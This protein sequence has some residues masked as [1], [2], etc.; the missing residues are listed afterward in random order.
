MLHCNNFQGYDLMS[1]SKL[2]QDATPLTP[3]GFWQENIA[4]WQ[5]FNQR[6]GQLWI[7]QVQRVAT[8]PDP[9]AEL[10]ETMTADLLRTVSD[11]NLRHWQNLASLLDSLPDWMTAPTLV[12]AAS[13]TDWFDRRRRAFQSGFD[14]TPK[15]TASKA[16]IVPAANPDDLTRIKG[17]GPKL[18]E[19]LNTLGVFRF[20]QIADWSA[21]DIDWIDTQV[22]GKGRIT[23]EDWVSQARLLTANG[24]ATVH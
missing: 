6:T 24:E 14:L 10:A 19:K 13:L 4:T 22:A 20:A 11:L 5:E 12:N 8:R 23:R 3:F 15:P 2:A 9:D 21:D 1:D 16:E 17:I 7:E 18:S